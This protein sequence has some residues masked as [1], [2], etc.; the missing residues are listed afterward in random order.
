[1][2]TYPEQFIRGWSSCW[3]FGETLVNEVD[4]SWRPEE[5]KV[6]VGSQ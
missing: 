6:M 4:E 2:T 1:M 3:V 5:T